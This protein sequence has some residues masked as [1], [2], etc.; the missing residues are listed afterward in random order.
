MATVSYAA[1]SK[2]KEGGSGSDMH[3][4]TQMASEEAGG[5]RAHQAAQIAGARSSAAI[6]I[7]K[8]SPRRGGRD[9]TSQAIAVQLQKQ[10]AAE[11]IQQRARPI[12]LVEAYVVS[13]ARL[14]RRVGSD[15]VICTVPHRQRA[16]LR[17]VAAAT[18]RGWCPTGCCHR[19]PVSTVPV[20]FD[21]AVEK[22]HGRCCCRGETFAA[23]ASQG[24]ALSVR[25]FA[26]GRGTSRVTCRESRS[27]DEVVGEAQHIQIRIGHKCTV[28][29]HQLLHGLSLELLP[30]Y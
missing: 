5:L 2:H 29:P 25:K 19:Y 20:A 28:Q 15:P 8:C 9:G 11:P 26:Y 3:L 14:V 4:N 17:I 16:R 1:R 10:T 30:G 18:D 6:T 13:N 27:N 7:E 24:K 12:V 22:S 21:M 23:E